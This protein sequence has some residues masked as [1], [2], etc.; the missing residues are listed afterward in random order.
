MRTELG[1]GV[2]AAAIGEAVAATRAF[3]RSGDMGEE[4]VLTR[5]AGS[6][7]ALAEAFLGAVPI[8]ATHEDVLTVN[9]QWQRLARAPVRAIAGVT[10]L[11]IGAAPFVLPVETY[12]IDIDGAGN[13]WVRV[14][15][16]GGAARVAVGYSAGLAVDWA[17]LP[18]GVAQGIVMLT[19]HLV[20]ERAAMT[21]PPAAVAALWRPWR[22][23]ALHP[24]PACAVRA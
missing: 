3:L 9:A 10:G 18:M 22:R 24:A 14:M 2:P 7:F 23:M 16:S 13:G 6:A 4:A 17:T 11:P 1:A 15:S 20:D 8:V 21:S 5:A 19:A 12:A